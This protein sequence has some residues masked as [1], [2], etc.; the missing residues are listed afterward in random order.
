MLIQWDSL[1]LFDSAYF[2]VGKAIFYTNECMK[3]SC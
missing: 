2:T 3:T 1:D